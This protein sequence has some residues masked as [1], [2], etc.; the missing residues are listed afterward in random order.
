LELFRV[1]QPSTQ[2]GSPS[3]TV[4]SLEFLHERFHV[5]TEREREVDGGEQGKGRIFGMKRD[6]K[7]E[8]FRADESFL[9]GEPL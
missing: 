6:G 4:F 7:A 9:Q 5:E 2:I 3:I 8:P 1:F